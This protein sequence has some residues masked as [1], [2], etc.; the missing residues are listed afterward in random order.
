MWQD[1][2]TRWL[3]TKLLCLQ[4][5]DTLDVVAC[6][7]EAASCRR[8]HSTKRQDSPTYG[9]TLMNAQDIPPVR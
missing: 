8:N 3:E 2:V 7:I 5:S 1:E 9:I 4:V 6:N